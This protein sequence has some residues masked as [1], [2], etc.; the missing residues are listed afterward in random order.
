MP[1]DNIVHSLT[2][3]NTGQ[4]MLR[5]LVLRLTLPAQATFTSSASSSGWQCGVD[6]VC[7]FNL[8]D[9]GPGEQGIVLFV[10]THNLR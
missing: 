6:S 7:S 8:G 3:A 2:Y 5:N 4:V 1:G 9:V 10:V